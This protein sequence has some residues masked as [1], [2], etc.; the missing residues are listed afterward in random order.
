[1]PAKPKQPWT[2]K[3]ILLDKRIAEMKE[4]IRTS[5]LNV[6]ARQRAIA[7]IKTEIRRIKLGKF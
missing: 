1:M 3:Q 2:N 7:K 6:R 5:H 4:Y